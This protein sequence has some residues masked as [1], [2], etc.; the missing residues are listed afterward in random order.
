MGSL[1]FEFSSLL[2]FFFQ[3]KP[4]YAQ[5]FEKA[6]FVWKNL[7]KNALLK[8]FECEAACN[9]EE[10]HSPGSFHKLSVP[11]LHRADEAVQ[12]CFAV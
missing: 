2:T 10:M 1:F 4:L 7:K 5:Q 11:E 3:G 8:L 9:D 6:W 12:V